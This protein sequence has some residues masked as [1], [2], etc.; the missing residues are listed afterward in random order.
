MT[1]AHKFLIG[2]VIL[3]IITLIFPHKKE[4]TKKAELKTKSIT[5]IKIDA[6]FLCQE[7]VKKFL[8]S[9]ASAKF[10]SYLSDIN[11]DAHSVGPDEYMVLSYV[12]S[13]NSFGA[14]IRTRYKCVLTY[15]KNKDSFELQKIDFP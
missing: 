7:F 4:E 2:I 14:M 15:N 12:D 13:Q 8:K 9:P 1:W 6:Y 11:A 3:F 10:P 5:S